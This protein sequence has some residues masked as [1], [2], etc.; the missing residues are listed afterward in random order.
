MIIMAY[1]MPEE[2]EIVATII[3]IIEYSPEND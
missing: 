1:N 2:P 3:G